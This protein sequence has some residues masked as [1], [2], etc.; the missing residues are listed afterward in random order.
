MGRVLA[1]VL[2]LA[3][4]ALGDSLLDR[5]RATRKARLAG[6]NKTWLEE[7]KKALALAPE[8]P[9]LLVSVARAQA[10]NGNFAASLELLKE[11][12]DR[13]AGV[14]LARVDQFKLLP[15]SPDLDELT[16]RSRA[17]L[18]AVPRAQPFAAIPD[19]TA[20]PEGVEYDPLSRRVF[21]GTVH[22]EILVVDPAG[23]VSTFVARGGPL[24][25]VLGIKVDARRRLLWAATGVFPE[26][27]GEAQQKPDAGISGVVAYSLKN[28][29]LV[30]QIWLDERPVLHG[31]NDLALARNGD[32][33]VT[34]TIQSSVYRLRRGKLSLLL[35]DE[36]MSLPNWIVLTPDQRRLYVAT[37]E[38]LTLIDLQTGKPRP[39]QV[40][41][42]AAVNGIDGLSWD[43][44][45]LIGVQGTPYLARVVRIE[46]SP[47]GASV[48]RLVTLN[49]RT[50]PEYSQTTAAVG[51]GFIYVV[52]SEPAIDTTGAPLAT[53]SKPQIVRI[54][55][56]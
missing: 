53:S 13:G 11:A 39:V 40:P 51:D 49:A 42:N 30:R 47:D 25:E 23:A 45:A 43:R 52:A 3:G 28:G 54:P 48:T 14:D 4:A 7:G 33:Y 35:R 36:R 32:V 9:D 1:A 31:F 16:A 8:H 55:L 38:G 15:P 21:T 26:F 20:R 50:P 56:R 12:I 18:A 10:L 24:R 34:D 6:D 29:K 27:A 2:L 44:G 46:L 5:I 22:G 17:N 37:A 41:R 19:A